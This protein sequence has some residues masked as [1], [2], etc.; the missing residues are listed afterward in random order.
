MTTDNLK[1]IE[2]QRALRRYTGRFTK[3]LT[4]TD[5]PISTLVSEFLRELSLLEEKFVQA[6]L[7]MPSELDDN[8]DAIQ[9]RFQGMVAWVRKR[10]LAADDLDTLIEVLTD[11]IPLEL[12]QATMKSYT[13]KAA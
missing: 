7:A 2:V 12:C 8:P 4:E 10:L 3:Q 5:V 13:R 6:V 1:W 9:G 11:K